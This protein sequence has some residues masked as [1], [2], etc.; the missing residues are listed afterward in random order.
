MWQYEVQADAQA[1]ELTV[2]ARFESEAESLSGDDKAV[3]FV[4]DVEY[5]AGPDWV[6]APKR[7][8]EWLLSCPK[9]ACRARYRFALG[10]AATALDDADTALAAGGLV[11]APPST[12]LLRPST[13]VAGKF[14]FHVSTA[15]P[16]RFATAA[17]P[18][19]NAPPD[20][21]E[22]ST[23]AIDE[24]SFALF[25]PF[26]E[27]TIARGTARVH[28]AFPPGSLN[29]SNADAV[30]WVRTGVNAI[31]AYFGHFPA[32]RSLVILLPGGRGPT[33]GVTLG[34]G[35]PAV[36]IR[37]GAG[38]TAKRTGDDWVVTH[39]LVHVSLPSLSPQH[40]WLSE[41]IASYLEP[42]V[43][44][45]AGLISPEKFWGDLADGAPQGLPEA[46][47]EG[48]ERTHTW[49][50]TYWGGALFCLVADVTLR[51]RTGNARSLDD[52]LRAV[53]QTGQ[54][55]EAH[56]EIEH[57]LDVADQGTGTQ[58]LHE[59]YRE[60]GF[61]PLPIDLPSLWK[62][63]GVRRDGPGVVFDDRAP[64]AS[65]RRAITRPD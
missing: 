55:V 31:G 57:W 59:L 62:R 52:A 7:G 60:M 35:G 20:T 63:L 33:R 19:M 3:A 37:V 14:R 36:L 2:V 51:E 1:G 12:W 25:G 48:L 22:E 50:R 11:V 13:P 4:H 21:Y 56:W 17:R 54:D 24:S 49:G 23:D 46:G 34:D 58:V 45:R 8:A 53:V 65:V 43:R 64:G 30:G 42:V 16:G 38:V 27:D 18:A 28:V 6:A 40:A 61:A 26:F 47:D 32:E 44:V 5:A 9:G 29:L 15:R 41:G 10:E 39:E